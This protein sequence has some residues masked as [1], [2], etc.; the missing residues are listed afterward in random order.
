M[1]AHQQQPGYLED[2]NPA[3]HLMDFI[4]MADVLKHK[5]DEPSAA[6][7]PLTPAPPK[8]KLVTSTRRP[9]GLE[10]WSLVT[11]ALRAPQQTITIP[12][13]PLRG[14]RGCSQSFTGGDPGGGLQ[15][16]SSNLAGGL[17]MLLICT[18]I[19]RAH[20]VGQIA[21][22]R[23][24]TA[25]LVTRTSPQQE[26]RVFRDLRGFSDLRFRLPFTPSLQ[27]F[28]SDLPF[29]T[30]LESF[31]SYLPFR[32]CLQNLPFLHRPWPASSLEH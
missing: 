28:P 16:C 21:A 14:L 1:P 25:R 8:P 3:E 27:N 5:K 24:K 29:R 4:H 19:D 6:P 26:A 30:S 22:T 32:P 9:V 18:I 11:E 23:C 10:A 2:D 17:T 13:W 31:P 20:I 15:G 12:Y 7:P